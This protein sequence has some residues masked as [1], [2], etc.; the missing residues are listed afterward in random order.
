TSTCSQ[1]TPTHEGS[2]GGRAKHVA[3]LFMN[4][5]EERHRG[6]AARAA[7]DAGK[8]IVRPRMPTQGKAGNPT[9]SLGV[10]VARGNMAVN[11]ASDSGCAGA[12]TGGC[13]A[14]SPASEDDRPSTDAAI[15]ILASL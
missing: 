12:T 4:L 5:R 8:P 13:S 1:A 11:L 9:S 15:D 7:S 10:E 3:E 6:G 14:E 2:A